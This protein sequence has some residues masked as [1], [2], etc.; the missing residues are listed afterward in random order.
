[1][2]R[3]RALLAQSDGDDAAYRDFRDSYRAMANQFGYQGHMALAAAM[4]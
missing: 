4:P 1:M 3:L 2:L